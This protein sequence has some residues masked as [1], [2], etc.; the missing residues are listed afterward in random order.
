M[1]NGWENDGWVEGKEDNPWYAEQ[2]EEIIIEADDPTI[3]RL[4][5]RAV[6]RRKLKQTTGMLL[7]GSL[8]VGLGQRFYEHFLRK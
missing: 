6:Q 8:I 3:E 1:S 4:T 7:I 2:Q 5:P